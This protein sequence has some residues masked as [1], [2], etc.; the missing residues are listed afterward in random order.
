M[1]ACVT[2]EDIINTRDK[3]CFFFTKYEVFCVRIFCQQRCQ[4]PAYHVMLLCCMHEKLIDNWKKSQR[5]TT[6]YTN[7]VFM[8]LWLVFL[9]LVLCSHSAIS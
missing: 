7:G 6:C 2:V 9:S 3:Y 1:T 5:S 4:Q 8:I